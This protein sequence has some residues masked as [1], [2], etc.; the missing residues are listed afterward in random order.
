M[1]FQQVQK[2][3]SDE[4]NDRQRRNVVSKRLKGSNES[5]IGEKDNASKIQEGL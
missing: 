4:Q 2:I 3:Q 5:N 1:N